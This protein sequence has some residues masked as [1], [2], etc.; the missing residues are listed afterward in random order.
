MNRSV[1][2]SVFL[3][4]AAFCL[5]SVSAETIQHKTI[6]V[7]A[8]VQK[9]TPKRLHKN[10]IDSDGLLFRVTLWKDG[11]FRQKTVLEGGMC[12]LD[13]NGK[14]SYPEANI[15]ITIDRKTESD[16]YWAIQVFPRET[17]GVYEVE[18]P[19][20]VLNPISGPDHDRLIVPYQ[21]GEVIRNP[22]DK[23][24]PDLGGR[25][26]IKVAIWYGV[27]G[28][29]LQ[30]MQMILYENGHDGVMVW[31]KDPDGYIKDFEVSTDVTDNY[32][33]PGVRCSVH[34][35]PSNTGKPG[36][37]WTS[38]YPVITTLYN[39]GWY[40]AAQVYRSWAVKQSW[41][42]QGLVIERIKRGDLPK[43]YMNNCLWLNA[44]HDAQYDDLLQ[45]S[46]LF[47]GVEIGVFVTQWAGWKVFGT[48]IPKYFPPYDERKYRRLLTLQDQKIHC[49]PYL[50]VG[51]YDMCYKWDLDKL[52]DS[53]VVPPQPGAMI[54]E[55]TA[56]KFPYM[57]KY[58]E[59]WSPDREKQN[60]LMT[61]LREAWSGPVNEDLLSLIGSDWFV[62]HK[63]YKDKLIQ[64]LR[65]H[66]GK[67]DT[68]IDTI[69][70]NYLFKPLC[71]AD[72]TWQDYFVEKLAFR[73]IE[74]YGTDG[75]YLD[76]LNY[77]GLWICWAEHHN[78]QPGFGNHHLKGSR[79]IARR[80]REKHPETV[81]FSETLHEFSIDVIQDGYCIHPLYYNHEIIPLFPTV[82]QG[83]TSM[84][85]WRVFPKT[86]ENL[87]NFAAAMAM[88]IHSGHKVGA[89]TTIT[90][91]VALF[92]QKNS[93][94]L[95]YFKQMVDMKLQTMDVFAYGRRIKDPQIEETPY[96]KVRFY[97]DK[98]GTIYK[99][100][101]RPV[102]EA[103]CWQ[104]HADPDKKLLL[105]SN[106]GD[107]SFNV[108][109]RSEE[110]AEGSRLTDL[111]G[112]T[113]V[114]DPEIPI[115]V[116]SFTYRALMTK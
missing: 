25:P 114:Y 102:L 37:A 95:D 96:H 81:L 109:V 104:S 50:N 74:E 54:P 61:K 49:F 6:Y 44:L 40:S 103:S 57:A 35:Y 108:N 92:D 8:P 63:S 58:E 68:I 46:K 84:H 101:N 51:L 71:R 85:E 39:N 80:I 105:I 10:I 107:K 41:C 21:F 22:F 56:E 66:W 87:N 82:Y 24:Q 16:T 28:S 115:E 110:I 88:T 32:S 93:R 1:F 90:T 113:I 38:P 78:H 106:S 30:A 70:I 72:K 100:F 64:G 2:L 31:T 99:E 13:E 43:W 91:Q 29:K 18:F 116:K 33:G 20:L 15:I 112:E 14:V 27:Y 48:E 12:D 97:L 62:G 23:Q 67:D 69:R 9:P 53:F 17:F 4:K 19:L 60:Y 42:S 3:L 75:I 83:Y 59:Y 86:L 45:F 5:P 26:R 11:D 55:K 34:H 94:A 73:N 89:F 65:E 52:R 36:T 98:P 77:A 7:D 76:T 47:P 79:E 111:D